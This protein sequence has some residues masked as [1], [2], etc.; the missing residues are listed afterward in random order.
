MKNVLLGS[1]LTM[2]LSGLDK[3]QQ[4]QLHIWFCLTTLGHTTVPLELSEREIHNY[5][6]I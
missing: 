5:S 1:I 2:L 3:D 6:L 4:L